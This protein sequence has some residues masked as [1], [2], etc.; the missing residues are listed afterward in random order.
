L[1]D[2]R[3]LTALQILGTAVLYT[4][5][6]PV[7]ETPFISWN[8]SLLIYLLLTGIFA[9]ALACYIQSSAQRFTTPNRA[10]LVFSLEPFFACLFAYL[11]LGQT[12]TGKEWLGGGLVLAGIVT[13][14]L[15]RNNPAAATQHS[16]PTLCPKTY[17]S[18][19]ARFPTKPVEIQH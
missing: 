4:L 14:E 17:G 13:S 3:Q 7:V 2:Y 6:A 19:V 9:T 11:L 16:L 5:M 1:S 8:A 10:A 18:D 15:R 12:M